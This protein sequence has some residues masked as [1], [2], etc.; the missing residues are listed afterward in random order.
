MATPE[1]SGAVQPQPVLAPVTPAAYFWWQTIDA[2]GEAAVYDALGN[3]SGLVRSVGFRDPAKKLS[4]VTSIGS[5]AWDRLFSGPRPAQLHPFVDATCSWAI[6]PAPPTASSTSPP[7]SPAVCSSR[8]Q[9]I[10]STTRRP[11]H[12]PPPPRANCRSEA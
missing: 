6:H 4:M 10:S 7:P 1:S 5:A 12:R 9:S 3:L 2:G 8:P 11:C